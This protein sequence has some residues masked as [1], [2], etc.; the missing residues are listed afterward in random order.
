MSHTTPTQGN[1]NHSMRTNYNEFGVDEYYRKVNASYRN[2]FFPGIRKVIF[3]LLDRWWKEEGVSRGGP[4]EP[5][6]ELELRILDMAAGSGEATLVIEEWYNTRFPSA[7][8]STFS[9]QTSN[10]PLSPAASP[11]PG[12][13]NP[14]ASLG[15]GSSRLPVVGRSAFV[16]PGKKGN[17]AET[18]A[19]S[20]VLAQKPAR[21]NLGLKSGRPPKLVIM[22]TDPYTVPAYE[23]RTGRPCLELSFQDIAQGKLAAATPTYSS[24]PFDLVICSFA[25]HLV[26]D[27][28]EMFSLLYEL[29]QRAKWLAVVAPHKKPEIKDGWGYARW[30]LGSWKSTLD[31]GIS[32]EDVDEHDDQATPSQSRDGIVN[33]GQELVLDRVRCRLYK[34]VEL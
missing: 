31:S 23:T 32:M 1:I 29:S 10:S 5:E 30:N 16:P 9:T 7:I 19:T 2:P 22:A 6:V 12:L 34:S 3:A 33:Q 20:S 8:P 17:Q 4:S 14:L 13:R 21:P 11:N 28:S 25:L 18:T 15:I 27:A 26:G 24:K